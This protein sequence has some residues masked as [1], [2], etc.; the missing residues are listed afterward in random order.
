MKLIISKL[1]NWLKYYN[2]SQNIL[3]KNID[4]Q[5]QYL[6]GACF[7]WMLVEA[8]NMYQLLITVFASVETHFMAK[9]VIFAWGKVLLIDLKKLI[10]HLI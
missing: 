8:L 10:F 3:I 6:V 2:Y 7:A 5:L 9:R 4:S 1:E